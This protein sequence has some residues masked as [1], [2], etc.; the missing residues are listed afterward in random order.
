MSDFSGGSREKTIVF[1]IVAIL[2]VA[3]VFLGFQLVSGGDPASDP[4]QGT[5]VSPG[6]G[7][8]DG[9]AGGGAPRGEPV[10]DVMAMIPFSEAELQTGAETARDFITSYSEARPEESD[11]ERLDRLSPMVSEEFFGA[12]ETLVLNTPDAGLPQDPQQNDASTMVTGIRHIGTESVIFVVEV[13]FQANAGS[14]GA[15]QPLPYA[16]AVTMV[17]QGGDWTVFAFQGAAV[18][19]VGEGG[20]A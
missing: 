4:G 12:L 2:V 7:A 18:G 20:G 5:S 17:P 11:E 15:N 13:H 16:Y 3:L 10:D 6:A 9:E 19:N 14:E 8:G 1:A